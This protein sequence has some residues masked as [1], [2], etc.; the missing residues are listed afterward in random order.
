MSNIFKG[1]FD[2]T[3]VSVISVQDFLICIAVSLLC[4]LI[5][6]LFCSG[7]NNDTFNISV[8]LLPAAVCVVIMMVN[9]NIGASLSVA[10]AFSL[11]RFRS[12]QGNAKQITVVFLAMAAGL[13]TGM[14]YLAYALMFTVLMCALMYFYTWVECRNADRFERFLYITIPESLDYTG[15]FDPILREY[16]QS[17]TLENVRT[18]NMG[19]LFRLTYRLSLKNGANEKDLIDELRCRNGNLEIHIARCQPYETAGM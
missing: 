4:G 12:A 5:I 16:A 17:S 14:G 6:R 3:A 8:A 15:V 13:I 1:I 2:S 19:S 10:G 7:R 11:I 18:T 9:G